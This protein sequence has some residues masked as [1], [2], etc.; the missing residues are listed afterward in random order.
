MILLMMIDTPE[1]KRKFVILYEKYRYLMFKI[2]RNILRDPYLAEDAVHDAFV[3]IAKNM[4]KIGEIESLYTKRYLVTVAK[5]AAI[6]L[7]RRQN[8]QRKQEMFVDELGENQLPVTYMHTD[9][10]NNLLDI[11]KDLPPKY[12]DIFL[13]KYSSHMSNSEIAQLLEIRE[14]TVRQRIFRGKQL[15]E[16]ALKKLEEI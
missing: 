13:L 16:D 2:A 6:D 15:I 11:L 3:H 10:E 8:R 12:R 1:D 14:G 7:Y 9:L 4:N 5:N